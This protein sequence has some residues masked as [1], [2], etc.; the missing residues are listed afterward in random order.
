VELR[1]IGH[2]TASGTTVVETAIIDGRPAPVISA[3]DG[4][5]RI[6]DESDLR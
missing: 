2:L 6:W 3:E 1:D 5:L 4:V